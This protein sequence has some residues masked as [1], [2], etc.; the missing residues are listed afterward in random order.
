[1]AAATCVASVHEPKTPVR[2]NAAGAA[3]PTFANM[4]GSITAQRATPKPTLISL[5]KMKWV[6]DIH[7]TSLVRQSSA[8]EF[9]WIERRAAT[10]N[11]INHIVSRIT[12]ANHGIV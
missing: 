5:G 12:N 7:A 4:P 9:Q 10:V 11:V 8:I 6:S 2:G 1:M 3:M